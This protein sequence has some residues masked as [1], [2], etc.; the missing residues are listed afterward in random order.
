MEEG[1][2]RRENKKLSKERKKHQR[3][4]EKGKSEK[5]NQKEKQ[6]RCFFSFQSFAKFLK[7]QVA[8][9]PKSHLPSGTFRAGHGGGTPSAVSWRKSRGL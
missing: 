7:V 9:A 6:L 8:S 5:E 2:K 1:N 4:S 3:Q